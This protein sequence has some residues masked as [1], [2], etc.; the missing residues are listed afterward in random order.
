MEEEVTFA[1]PGLSSFIESQ[2][3][4]LSRQRQMQAPELQAWPNA[5]GSLE[6]SPDTGANGHYTAKPVLPLAS[7]AGSPELW[8]A[9]HIGNE[10]TVNRL[11]QQGQCNGKQKDASGH[12]VLWHAIAFGHIGIAQLMLDT[13]PAGG[14][15][16][17]DAL[18]VH[19]RKG[20]TLLHLLCQCRP[21]TKET[22]GLF[23]RVAEAV[24]ASLFTK[25]NANGQ[26]FLALA[27]ASP[28]FWVLKHVALRYPEQMKALLSSKEADQGKPPLQQLLQS[29]PPPHQPG[30]ARPAKIP[31]H[32][33][34]ASMLSPDSTGRVPF[35]DLAF[36][37]TTGPDSHSRFLA[38]RVV[39]GAQ[40]PVLLKELE[41]LPLVE[42][43]QEGITAAL[44]KV[45]R[46]ISKEVWRSVLQF[47]Y[48]G[49]VNCPFAKDPVK[50][51]E[52]FRAAAIY[53]LP[54][55]L[56]DL[57]QTA[58]A[59]AYPT[60]AIQSSIPDTS[61]KP[62]KSFP[63]VLAQVAKADETSAGIVMPLVVA[64][65]L[66]YDPENHRDASKL[67]L[68]K[69]E[70]KAEEEM[71]KTIREIELKIQATGEVWDI[72]LVLAERLGIDPGQLTFVAKQG[73]FWRENKD[74]EEIYSK[75]LVKGVKSFERERAKHDHPFVIIGAGHIGL[76]QAM[77]FLKY[78]E[79]NFVVFDRKPKVGGMAW[80]DQANVTSKLQTEV[81]V[82][83]LGFDE[84]LPCPKNDYPWPSRDELLAMFQTGAEEYGILPYCRLATE[85]QEIKAEG[86]KLDT[87]YE[88][89]IQ[90]VEKKDKAEKMACAG[91]LMYPGNLSL[92]RR[93]EYKGED[94]FGGTIAYGMFDEFGYA[95]ATGK[96]IAIVGHGA[97]AVENVRS[98]CEYSCKKIYLVCRRKNIACPRYVSWLA[99]QSQSPLSASLFLHSMKPMYDLMG[100]DV[101]SYYG[102][103]VLFLERFKPS[104]LQA[105]FGIGDVY[106]CALS[107]GKLEVIEASGLKWQ[108]RSVLEQVLVCSFVETRLRLWRVE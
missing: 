40:S 84:T 20:D 83:H 82:Y 86:Q 32:F 4:A 31:E 36:D 69:K 76:R 35:A 41:T 74:C 101:W 48:T 45:D 33:A 95:E 9:V 29:L 55:A 77:V 102:V 19:P 5:H 79:N 89:T 12:S 43:P 108:R 93:E 15:G 58:W 72:K 10:A 51:V 78:G 61:L 60:E 107:W 37:V 63:S 21:F 71:S 90:H 85:V 104:L 68:I 22:A 53:K 52:L 39:V 44:F 8:H 81:G 88:V 66:W 42:L 56:L 57:A 7:A 54:R 73:P 30:F 80:W 65:K 92:P 38:H 96:D 16:G 26:S 64:D 50:L 49:V 103:Q 14:Q 99:N 87:T 98:C 105:R 23:K 75:V 1:G 34:V 62:R 70:S 24:P 18:E 97:F 67:A 25:A 106:F 13:Y 27:T 6:K 46:R 2:R 3:E 11:I 28:N 17:I 91:I 47:F 94:E 59:E 100:W